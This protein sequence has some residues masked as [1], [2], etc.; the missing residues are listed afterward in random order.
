ML[1]MSES[2]PFDDLPELMRSLRSFG[3]R[4]GPPNDDGSSLSDQNRFFAPLLDGR[5]SAGR[6]ISRPQV[7]AAF[8][9]RRLT[10][11]ID[12][13]MRAF[14]AERFATRAPARR[15]LEAEL[16][17]IMEP[18]RGAL[19]VL[20]KLGEPIPLGAV[21][22]QE[23]HWII[24]L[25]QLRVVFHVA[26]SRW[27]ALRAALAASPRRPGATGRWPFGSRGERR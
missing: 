23:E 5:R 17:E 24:W 8:D 14:A 2:G 13:T 11:A 6:A 19:Q 10:A 15:A 25:T 21:T 18:L 16:F 7:V 12:A 20:A 26:D 1:P 22:V 9:A 4:R 27:P 3:S